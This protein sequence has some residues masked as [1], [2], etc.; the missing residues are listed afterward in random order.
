MQP[1]SL[2]FLVIIGIW[3]AYFVQYWV[4][5]R[6]HLATIRSVDAF[7]E[8]MRVLQLRAPLSTVD[9]G[10]Q[11]P[12]TY[13]VSPAR[14]MRPQVT[15]KRA[16]ASTMLREDSAAATSASSP[17]TQSTSVPRQRPL[18]AREVEPEVATMRPGRA[19]RGIVLVVGLLGTV[20]FGLLAAFGVLVAWAPLVPLAMAG[21]GFGW[22]RA[23]VRA[24]VRARREAQRPLRR[25]SAPVR[26]AAPAVAPEPVAS[27]EQP[28]E[29]EVATPV[30]SAPFDV[31]AH[32][33]E[34]QAEPV[35][36]QPVVE[37]P[38]VQQP[39]VQQP[40]AEHEV[41]LPEVDE[42]DIPLTWD[43]RPVPRPTYTMKAKA[44]ER[45]FAAPQAEP[46]REAEETAY[47]E[48]PQRRI[49][50]L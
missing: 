37:Q 22:L 20:V 4:R 44:P 23:G 5:R 13:A 40:A 15:V 8:T 47:D 31:S 30:T 3:A 28:V 17:S 6:E 38:V 2:I 9:T 10:S 42:D 48:L 36:E 19:T 12:R 7:S 50:G 11:A 34:S 16:E 46:E 29:A 32:T 21:A 49:S 43:P 45:P 24:E 35:L 33:S 14:A 39:V 18:P 1:S 41:A 26:P 25:A 27:S